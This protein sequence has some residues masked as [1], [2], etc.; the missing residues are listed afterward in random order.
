MGGGSNMLAAMEKGATDAF[1]W[2]APQ[3]RT[4]VAR[5]IGQI[6]IDPFTGEIP[7]FEGVYYMVMVTSR[8]TLKK[9]PE[10]IRAAARALARA[11]K[12]AQEHP[13]EAR[14]LVR[15]QFSD[16]DEAVFNAAWADYRKAIPTTPV[17]TRDQYAKTQKWLNI[18]AKPPVAVPY[19]SVIDEANAQRAAAEILGK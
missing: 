16:T 7:E 12:F 17:I 9:Q 4:A 2:A 1:L 5:G 11:M 10:V 3:S 14:K 6:V 18:T 15:A 13:D 19:E 8:D